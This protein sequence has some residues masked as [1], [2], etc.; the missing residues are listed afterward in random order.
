MRPVRRYFAEQRKR[1][2]IANWKTAW[3]ER[4]RQLTY[5]QV[6]EIVGVSESRAAVLCY[7]YEEYLLNQKTNNQ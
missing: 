4:Q 3:T 1:D 7:N 6:G 5:K 2:A